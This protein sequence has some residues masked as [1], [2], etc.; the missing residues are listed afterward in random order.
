M[1]DD[2]YHLKK[3]IISIV[4][5]IVENLAL[6]IL[7]K[8]QRSQEDKDLKLKLVVSNDIPFYFRSGQWKQQTNIKWNFEDVTIRIFNE[9]IPLYYWQWTLRHSY[10][11]SET[12][13]DRDNLDRET[14]MQNTLLVVNN[15]KTVLLKN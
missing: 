3:P 15:K 1:N 9:N 11:Q 10:H 14:C 6:C 2:R 5:E 8:Y 12:N 4:L 7:L 13:F